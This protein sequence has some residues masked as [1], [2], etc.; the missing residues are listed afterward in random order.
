VNAT[1]D[2]RTRPRDHPQPTTWSRWRVAAVLGG[3]ATV[4][5]LVW[6]VTMSREP[7]GLTDLTLYPLFA[8]GIAEGRGYLS[9]GQHP[10]AY[11]PPGY[12]YFLGA[13]QWLSDRVG[14]G[15]HLVLVAGLVQAVLGGVAVGAVVIAAE[16]LGGRRCAI[17]AGTLMALWP[18]LV[19]HSSLMLSETL[20]IA[21]F[22]V[23]LAALLC[24]SDGSRWWSTP[25][26]IAA[27]GLGLCTLI[28]PQ[29]TFLALPAIALA[30][31]LHSM[32]WRRWC[33]RMGVLLAGIVLVVAPWTIRNAVVL[34]GFV[35]VSTNTGDNLCMGFNPDTTG[36]FM[37]A[38]ECETGEFY[39]Q[40]IDQEL[41][42]DAEARQ[43]A[44]DWASGHL[45]EL[46]SLSLRKL[47][48][49]YANDRDGLRALESFD[50]DSFLSDGTR[51]ALGAVVDVY[52]F[53]VLA[54]AAVGLVLSAV[55]GWRGRRQ[56]AAPLLVV[57][58]TLSAAM[59]PVVSFADTR[60]KVPV[61]PCYAI[62]AAVALVAVWDRVRP[63]TT[64]HPE[65]PAT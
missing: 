45:G 33:A 24:A 30:W 63:T 8:E 47:Q 29:S 61:A 25:L 46:P 40:G 43:R 53:T 56:D 16:R 52:F 36:G 2:D 3:A 13:L 51:R 60:F 59:V 32:G 27:V 19:I 38:P 20:F 6:V 28:R 50:Q 21:V 39:V 44:L 57:L 26:L 31:A 4:L 54:L 42:R 64:A 62:L 10:T 48:I 23:T 37:V 1:I 11:Y 7:R 58:L 55:R 18:N 14:L 65:E 49:T 34:D 15:D 17:V 41:R 9:L 5:R 35:P 22:T 12:P